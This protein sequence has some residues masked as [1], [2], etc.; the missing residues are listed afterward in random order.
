MG[1]AWNDVAAKY[2]GDKKALAGLTRT[3]MEGSNPYNS[4]WKGRV[5]GLA[6]PPNAVAIKEA[7]ATKLVDW[8]LA[9]PQ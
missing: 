8:I 3:V 4:H 1:P 2:K 7:G 5:S 9:L 6:M